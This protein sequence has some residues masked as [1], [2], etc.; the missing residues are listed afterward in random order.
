MIEIRTAH[1]LQSTGR[2]VTGYAAV[3]DSPADLG[4]FV[5]LVKPGAFDASLRSKVNVRALYDHQGPAI[6]GTTKS[7]TLRLWSDAKGLAFAMDIPNT[8]VGNDVLEL[9]KRGDVSGCSFGFIV[10]A[11]GDAWRNGDK[12]IRELR[13]VNLLEVTLTSNPAYQ[14]TEVALR[15]AAQAKRRSDLNALWLETCA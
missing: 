1:G 8:T 11:G 7:Q 14:A 6:L 3:Y 9:V 10:P 5:E 2:T 13:S 12:P 4:D 15:S